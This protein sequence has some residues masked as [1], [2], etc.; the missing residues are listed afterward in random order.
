MVSSFQCKLSFYF[1]NRH[2]SPQIISS[3]QG[4]IGNGIRS[5]PTDKSKAISKFLLTWNF[6]VMILFSGKINECFIRQEENPPHP[7]KF[8]TGIHPT[9]NRYISA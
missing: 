5:P 1:Q 8:Q 6:K 3:S 7:R 2:V 4:N 9:H